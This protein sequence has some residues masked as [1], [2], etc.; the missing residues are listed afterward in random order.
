MEAKHTATPWIKV[1]GDMREVAVTTQARINN[2]QVPL[3]EIDVDYEGEIGD[4]QK[5][6]LAFILHARAHFDDLVKALTDAERIIS[7]ALREG[8]FAGESEAAKQNKFNAQ[9]SI[10]AIRTALAKAG[11]T[12]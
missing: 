11:A 7:T 8:Q 9:G 6:G 1:D 12:P 5:A 10:G 2:S 3:F 4:E